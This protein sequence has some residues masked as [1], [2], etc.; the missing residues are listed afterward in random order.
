MNAYNGLIN[1]ISCC[2]LTVITAQ[3]LAAVLVF[4]LRAQHA[5]PA[6][7]QEGRLANSASDMP[8]RVAIDE[9]REGVIDIEC[10]VPVAVY[11]NRQPQPREN[12]RQVGL[13]GPVG[14]PFE[15]RYSGVRCIR[16]NA[17]I[18]DHVNDLIGMQFTKSCEDG[19]WDCTRGECTAHEKALR[20]CLASV[21]PQAYDCSYVP[22]KPKWGATR[23]S[24]QFLQGAL[25]ILAFGFMITMSVLFVIYDGEESRQAGLF[26]F[27][28]KFDNTSAHWAV[29]MFAFGAM[30]TAGNVGAMTSQL[31]RLD[32]VS[33][34][35]A[36]CTSG[37]FHM[38]G[39]PLP[40]EAPWNHDIGPTL[41]YVM[42]FGSLL[43]CA[44]LVASYMGA[45]YLSRVSQG[46]NE[47]TPLTA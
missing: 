19:R 20:L 29:P 41:Y 38:C 16:N 47:R 40:E 37:E 39:A 42:H 26:E 28:C 21:A 30:F 9:P 8:S 12:L 6:L 11:G 23:T 45:R 22:D 13:L 18:F 34:L 35:D 2:L 27:R 33:D 5:A 31:L 14:I 32:K 25:K 4:G 24:D 17:S 7:C 10:L 36:A 15:H 44:M 46:A 3:C 1:G 43:C